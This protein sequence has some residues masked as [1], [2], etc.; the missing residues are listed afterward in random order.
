LTVCRLLSSCLLTGATSV[1]C[2]VS[3]VSVHEVSVTESSGRPYWAA[4]VSRKAVHISVWVASLVGSS[5]T[6]VAGTVVAPHS[7][8]VHT[9]TATSGACQHHHHT[10]AMGTGYVS[11]LRT[12]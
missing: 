10:H 7:A 1:L 12:T 2:V 8:L 3:T 6:A 11:E 5:A 4:R 9:N